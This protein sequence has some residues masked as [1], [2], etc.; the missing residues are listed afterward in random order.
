LI[1]KTPFFT[2]KK[3]L[4]KFLTKNKDWIEKTKRTVLEKIKDY[5]E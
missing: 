3:Y 1:V 2:S 5:N 4:D